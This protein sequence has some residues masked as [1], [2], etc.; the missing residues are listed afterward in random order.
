MRTHLTRRTTLAGALATLAIPAHAAPRAYKLVADRSTISFHFVVNGVRQTGT[1]PV[2]TANIRVD[3]RNLKASSAKVTA[4][5]RKARTGLLFITEALKSEAI[6]HAGKHPIVSFSSSRIQLGAKGRISEGAQIEG[7]LRLR[8]V[9]RSIA[10]DATLSRPAGTPPDDLSV[11]Y[12][13]LN[14]TISRSAFGASGFADL[15]AN[16]VDID[17]RAEIHEE[18]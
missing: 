15:V 1:I 14:G 4:D 11:L 3:T 17:I 18:S 13:K 5:V 12:V 8:G 7:L 9:T 6:L 2:R 10:F 16:D